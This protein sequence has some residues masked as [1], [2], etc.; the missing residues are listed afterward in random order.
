MR[1]LLLA[2]MAGIL[3][4]TGTATASA[5]PGRITGHGDTLHPEG[6]A[7]DPTRNAFL[8]GSLFHG[9]VSVVGADGQARTLI[10]DPD[11][12]V[13]L[14][15][16]VDAIRHRVLVVTV[17][18]LGIFDLRTGQRLHLV[19]FGVRPNDVTVDWAGNAYVSDPG[20]DSVFRVDLAGQVSVQVKDPKL[21]DP[22]FGL[23]GIAWHPAGYLLGIRYWDGKLMRISLRDSRVDEVR[24][25]K[26]LVGGDGIA[27]RPDGSLIVVTNHLGVPG[28]EDAVTV[29]RPNG[30]WT[31]ATVTRHKAW[32]IVAPTTV[33]VTPYGSYVLNG[34]LDLFLGQPPQLSDEFFITRA[35]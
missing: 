35:W 31:S 5:L 10:H 6:V 23:N 13:T 25:D 27:L 33:A 7:W 28:G 26:P 30:L 15:L 17:D 12:P 32:P 3:L 9:D 29:L 4:I 22:Q 1:K 14:G 34:R 16:H 24:L 11:M 21:G 18:G 8:I 19:K 2:V 20:S